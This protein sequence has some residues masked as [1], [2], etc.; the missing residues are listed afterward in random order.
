ML[1]KPFQSF[2]FFFR[3]E[4]VGGGGGRVAHPRD[5]YNKLGLLLI[6]QVNS[7]VIIV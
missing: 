2:F 4:E 3:G 1:F 7:I 6:R 5:T